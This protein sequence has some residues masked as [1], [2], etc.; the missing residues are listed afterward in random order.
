MKLRLCLV[1]INLRR[2]SHHK[3]RPHRR[4]AMSKSGAVMEAIEVLY[5]IS[6]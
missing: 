3:Y 6:T 5:F 4:K 2:E 1:V